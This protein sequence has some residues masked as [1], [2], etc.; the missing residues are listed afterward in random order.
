MDASPGEWP[1]QVWLH[2]EGLG[3]TCGGSLIARD[4]VLT[5]AHCILEA[6]RRLYQVV[7]GDLDRKEDEMSEQVHNRSHVI[8]F[9]RGCIKWNQIN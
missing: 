6:D 3:F 2:I 8:L 7:V 1:W 4:W 9:I 5:A